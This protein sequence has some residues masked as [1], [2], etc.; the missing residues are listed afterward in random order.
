[1]LA[2]S[3]LLA[4]AP[5]SSGL[6][7]RRTGVRPAGYLWLG[8]LHHLWSQRQRD[9]V[10]ASAKRAGLNA[11]SC[12]GALTS[13]LQAAGISRARLAQA[14]GAGAARRKLDSIS[15]HG[16]QATVTFSETTGGQKYVETD[17]LVREGG[18]WRADRIVKRS[19]VR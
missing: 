17:A 13:L 12:A 6:V 16:N 5:G 9:N 18:R 19:L 3:V 4:D 7:S 8:R 1:M 11:S 2:T 10:L 15:V 14:L